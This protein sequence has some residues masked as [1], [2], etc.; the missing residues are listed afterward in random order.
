MKHLILAIL[1]CLA[2]LVFLGGT[3]SAQQEPCGTNPSPVDASDPSIIVT[4][5]V[6]NASVTSP[7]HV[8]GQARVFEATVSLRL[9]RAD[10]TEAESTA[11]AAEGGVLSDFST[12]ISF[13]A[14]AQ[15]SACLWVYEVSAQDGSPRNVV[16][17]P[18][19]LNTAAGLPTTGSAAESS[20][21]SQLA[22]FAG[23]LA[24]AGLLGV[25][26]AVRRVR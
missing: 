3:A 10:G 16:Q 6:A 13:A 21:T 26:F 9:I 20:T 12:D 15:E 22:W 17:I 23:T 4:A 2:V 7:L 5:P 25:A 19:T 1:V 11:Q 24:L 8:E 18:L 14:S